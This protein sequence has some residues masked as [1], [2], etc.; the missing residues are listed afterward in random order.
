MGEALGRALG[1]KPFRHSTVR[2]W[3]EE[4]QEPESFALVRAIAQLL[5]TTVGELLDATNGESSHG[6]SPIVYGDEVVTTPGP[7]PSELHEREADLR[8]QRKSRPKKR[9]A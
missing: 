9:G 6:P 2:S 3:F 8:D 4:G 7:M 5:G 1:R